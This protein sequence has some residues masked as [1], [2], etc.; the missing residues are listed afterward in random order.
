MFLQLYE[1]PRAAECTKIM[2]GM[3]TKEGSRVGMMKRVCHCI[4]LNEDDDTD[5]LAV[6]SAIIL[7]RVRW[8]G[9][10]IHFMQYAV[11]YYSRWVRYGTMCGTLLTGR[12]LVPP[13]WK[14]NHMARKPQKS[15]TM[16]T[17]IARGCRGFVLV[18]NEMFSVTLIKTN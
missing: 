18:F 14:R 12:K 11:R 7:W 8:S 2:V 3:M 4:V 6:S 9:I 13:R 1:N 16:C 17:G 15:L 10:K 5:T